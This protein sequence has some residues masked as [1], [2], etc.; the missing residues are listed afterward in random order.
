MDNLERFLTPPDISIR[1]AIEVLDRG[2][3]GIVLLVDEERRLVGTVTDGDV[4]RALLD[5]VSL[6]AP[7][8]ALLKYRP[9]DYQQPTTAP[10]QTERPVLLDMMQSRGIRQIPLLDEAGRVVDLVL[11]SDLV[12]PPEPPILAV[13]MAGGY[14]TRL[15]PL[16]DTL[17]KPMLPVGDRPLMELIIQQLCAA[18]IRRIN[19]TTH[20]K[21]E[22]ILKYFGDGRRFGVKIKYINE[23]EPMGTAGA[24]SLL[25]KPRET[26]LVINGDILTRLNFQTMFDFHREHQAD[27]TVAVRKYTLHVPYG[28]VEIDGVAIS[29]LVEKPSFAFFV[30]AGIYLLEPAVLSYIPANSRLDMPDLIKTILAGGKRLVSFPIREYWMD[31]G[32]H[33]DYKQALEDAENGKI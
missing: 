33:V 30:N 25:G 14:G 9:E 23:T 11:L 32:Q 5:G 20:Y 12:E 7:V 28:L 15:Q 19:V 31:I 10:A 27:M 29:G 26:L 16:T 8:S 6:D 22:A 18:G 1:E 4:R 21:P 24:L 3:A 17:P 13:V 2:S